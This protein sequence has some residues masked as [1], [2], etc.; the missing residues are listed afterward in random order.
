MHILKI[1]FTCIGM[2]CFFNYSANSADLS[3]NNDFNFKHLTNRE[4][5]TNNNI[6]CIFQDKYGQIWIGTQDGLNCY[7]GLSVKTYYNHSSDKMSLPSNH[8]N[9]INEDVNGDIWIATMKGLVRYLPK[10]NNFKRYKKTSKHNV[11]GIIK[12]QNNDLFIT[13][14]NGIYLYDLEFDSFIQNRYLSNFCNNRELTSSLFELSNGNYLITIGL[15]PV[16]YNLERRTIQE[17]KLTDVELKLNNENNLFSSLVQTRDSSFLIASKLNGLFSLKQTKE[18]WIMTSSHNKILKNTP[19]RDI[20]KDSH[21]KIWIST[22]KGIYIK[23]KEGTLTHITPSK[24]NPNS[25]SYISTTSIYEAKDKSIWIGTYYGGVNIYRKQNNQFKTVVPTMIIPKL[26]HNSIRGIVYDELGQ[27]WIG[28]QGGGIL[29]YKM[30]ENRIKRLRVSKLLNK[31]IHDLLIDKYRR[32]WIATHKSGLLMYDLN[33]NKLNK[34][35]LWKDENVS[36]SSIITTTTNQLWVNSIIHGIKVLQLSP[37]GYKTINP[38][39]NPSSISEKT[40]VLL[41]LKSGDIA[42]GSNNG[43]QLYSPNDQIVNYIP[44]SNQQLKG[45]PRVQEIFQDSHNNIWLGTM[46]DGLIKIDQKGNSISFNKDNGLKNNSIYNIIEDNSNT[47]WIT[48]N[49]GV[50]SLSLNNEKICNY[51]HGD[52][53]NVSQFSLNSSYLHSN[54]QLYL[55]SIN[56]LIIFNPDSLQKENIKLSPTI[57][58]IRILNK[59]ITQINNFNKI[60]YENYHYKAI[61]LNYHQ[62]SI[63]LQ[64]LTYYYGGIK[65]QLF[66]YRLL[67][68]NNEWRQTEQRLADYTNLDPGQYTFQLQVLNPNGTWS[69]TTELHIKIRQVWYKRQLAYFIY[70]LILSAVCFLAYR[71]IRYRINM[72]NQILNSKLEIERTEKTNEHK[73]KFFT[74]VS[75][76]FRTPLTLIHGPLELLEQ[77]ESDPEKQQL[78]TIAKRNSGKLLQLINTILDFRLAQNKGLPLNLTPVKIKEFIIEQSSCFDILAEENKI[79]YQVEIAPELDLLTFDKDRLAIVFF[80]ILSNAFK[81]TPNGQSIIIK[82]EE[83]NDHFVCS[84]IDS[85]IGIPADEL[86]KVFERFYQVDNHQNNK[87]SGSGIGLA[88]TKEIIKQHSGDIIAS[89]NNEKG[90]TIQFTIPL[91]LKSNQN[92]TQQQTPSHTN[93]VFQSTALKSEL[94]SNNETRILL[95]D[96]NIDLLNFVS[97]VLKDNYHIMIAKDGHEAI[98]KLEEFNP[99]IIISDIMMPQIDGIEL[100]EKIKTDIKYS[101]IPFIFLSAKTTIPDQITGLATGADIYMTKPFSIDLLKH[102]LKSINNLISNRHKNFDISPKTEDKQLHLSKKDEQFLT[103]LDNLIEQNITDSKLSNILLAQKLLISPSTLYRKSIAI[104]GKGIND[105]IRYRKI[106]KAIEYLKSGNYNISEIAYMTG[107]NTPSYFSQCFKKETGTLPREYKDL[108][109]T[110]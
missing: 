103:D 61:D 50:S 86:T 26:R 70:I 68:F 41:E 19:I 18:G 10:T 28:T 87:N 98:L 110:S 45:T 13:T 52:G 6:R 90:T 80:N 78:I 73:L 108:N 74:N 92:I 65:K 54:N 94:G 36:I 4:G 63:T 48:T 51:R 40:R 97:N 35:Q 83:K 100:C 101:H 57:N 60:S 31:N 84:V 79:N 5:L 9:D 82:A 27:F 46:E 49:N 47:L 7:N 38:F 12:N 106:L 66:R 30:T 88:L 22:Y 96:D 91:N 62:R 72:Q 32:L 71:L 59:D 43:L 55:G 93:R 24:F 75:H 21:G 56:G 76:E 81:F 67:N 85:G 77:K 109:H 58:N 107:F 44:I 17:I 20:I 29:L 11:L 105:Y 39:V 37:K 102:Q 34:I 99:H 3:S 2:I 89:R 23:S 15:H 14:S 33:S 64:F 1:I 104:T 69:D 95:V 8:I 42:I 53:L 25:L 16:I